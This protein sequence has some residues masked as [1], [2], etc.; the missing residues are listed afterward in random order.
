M[1]ITAARLKSFG[2]ID[3]IVNEP[4]GGAHRDYRAVSQTLRRALSDALRSFSDLTPSQL[5]E[6]RFERLMAY[7]KFKG[8][9]GP[10]IVRP[11]SLRPR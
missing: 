10:L 2:L 7:G 4:V 3:K 8:S 5:V 11:H 1:G 6:R 9:R